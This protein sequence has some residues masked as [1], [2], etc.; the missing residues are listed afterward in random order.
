M[1][2]RRWGPN[3]WEMLHSI[4]NNYPI[5]PNNNEKMNFLIFFNNIKYVLPCRFC[6]ES[7]SEFIEEIKICEY[8]NSTHDLQKWL[9]K[10]HNKVNNKLRKQ[11]LIKWENP[12][13]KSVCEKYNSNNK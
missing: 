7:F 5:K 10:I 1:D 9:Y 3:G 13:F 8:L 6:R 12:T 11:K 4:A 2:T